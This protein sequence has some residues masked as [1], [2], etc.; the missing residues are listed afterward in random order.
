MRCIFN[1]KRDNSVIIGMK[2]KW[3]MSLVLLLT[4]GKL[5]CFKLPVPNIYINLALF[6]QTNVY[7]IAMVRSP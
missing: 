5:E 1:S 6:I 3:F 4:N 2:G 7:S